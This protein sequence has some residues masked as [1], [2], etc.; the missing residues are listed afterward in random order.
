MAASGVMARSP[1]QPVQQVPQPGGWEG[2]ASAAASS[3]VE[4][5]SSSSDSMTSVT[6]E[7]ADLHGSSAVLSSREE[8]AKVGRGATRHRQ[9]TRQRAGRE[10]GAS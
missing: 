3:V 6:K 4:E 2:A 1:P 10:G 8:K 9:G 5:S 7:V